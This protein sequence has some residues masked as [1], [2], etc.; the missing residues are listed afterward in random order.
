MAGSTYSEGKEGDGENNM[1]G[2]GARLA[3]AR[4]GRLSG[5]KGRATQQSLGQQ[6]REGREGGERRQ[7]PG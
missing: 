3:G 6:R 2:E 1:D 4:G 7:A 5:G